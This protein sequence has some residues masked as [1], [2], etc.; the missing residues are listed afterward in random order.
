ML[1]RATRG[2]NK[3]FFAIT[4]IKPYRF[5]LRKENA[6]KS[7]VSLA[8]FRQFPIF[9][10]VQIET[11]TYCNRKCHGCPVSLFPREKAFMSD[12]TFTKIVDDLSGLRF[13]GVIHLHSF[14]EPLADRTIVE[15]VRLISKSLPN[16]KI[17]M[18]SNGDFLTL[19]LLK[20]LVS[21]GLGELYVTQYDGKISDRLLK[22]LDKTGNREREILAV[23]VKSDL[24]FV[25]NR[26]GLLGNV[27]VYEPMLADCNRPS[28]HL[29]INYKGDVVICCNDYL[30][31]MFFGNVMETSLLDIWSCEKFKSIRRLLRLKMRNRI[32]LCRRCNFYGDIY[33]YRD[34]TEEEIRRFNFNVRLRKGKRGMIPQRLANALDI[35]HGQDWI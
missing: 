30:G 15:K 18:N 31:E 22:I 26:A 16:A 21:A 13:S 33:S 23:R 2:V 14:N 34:L 29:V 28:N 35:L 25:G 10:W 27:A 3:V 19:K 20:Q 4:G 8:R 17:K 12:E 9:H 5:L 24:D 32:E 7:L 6:K 11:S 1:E